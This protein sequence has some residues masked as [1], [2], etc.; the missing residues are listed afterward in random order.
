[1]L[2]GRAGNGRPFFYWGG[3]AAKVWADKSSL[4]SGFPIGD[5]APIVLGMHGS[6]LFTPD[7]RAGEDSCALMASA[8]IFGFNMFAF[9]KMVKNIN[10]IRGQELIL[11]LS[12]FPNPR[13][14]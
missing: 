9:S 14:R 3:C 10:R 2:R 4:S 8:I 11:D 12:S 7:K 13:G 5:S 1:M 6:C